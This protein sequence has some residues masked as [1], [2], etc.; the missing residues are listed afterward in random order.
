MN[1]HQGMDKI[2]Q[3]RVEKFSQLF[4]NI[5]F[6][7]MPIGLYNGKMGLCIYFYELAHLTSKKKYNVFAEKLLEDVIKNIYENTTVDTE[8]GLTGICMAINYLLDKGYVKGN[9]NYVLKDLD[10][11]IIKSLLFS[12]IFEH[13]KKPN[14]SILNSLLGNIVYLT[15]RLQNTKLNNNERNTM[16]NVI[17]ENINKIESLEVEKFTEP[18]FFSTTEY[19]TPLYLQSLQRIYQLNFYDYKIEKIV[20]GISS[21]ILYQYPVNKA[22]RM[23]ICQTMNEAA[24]I[25]KNIKG[26]DEHIEALRQHLDIPQIIHEFRNKNMAFSNGLCGF[27]YLLKKTG[28]GNGYKDLFLNKISNSDIWDLLSEDK[29]ILK[30]PIGL[31][32]GISGVIL[33]YLHILYNS[34]CDMFFDKV[35]SQYV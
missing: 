34:D 10:D 9:P 23:L 7:S 30:A 19:F 25:F 28:R 1:K 31:Y 21:H 18:T 15:I 27:Y 2:M 17:I 4:M 8:N 29:D 13:E 32:D 6:D 11:K 26:W 33:T 12:R 24:A 14:L 35:I 5:N 20:E 22:N 3:E 16:Q